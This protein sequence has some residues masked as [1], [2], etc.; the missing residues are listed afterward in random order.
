MDKKKENQTDFSGFVKHFYNSLDRKD[1]KTYADW[2][3]F[4]SKS[5]RAQYNQTK[6]TI[7][8]ALNGNRYNSALEIGPGDGIW[9][10]L[11]LNFCSKIDAIDL[12]E[13]MLRMAKERLNSKPVNLMK[14]DFL[15][16]HFK[17]N[18][19][20]IYSVRCIEYIEDKE[21]LIRKCKSL[22]K[23]KGHLLFVTKNPN[24]FV[25]KKQDKTLHSKQISIIKLKKLLENQGFKVKLVLPA[26]F[27]KGFHFPGFRQFS[28]LLHKNILNKKSGYNF[29]VKH[30]SESFLIFA[31][32]ENYKN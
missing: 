5:S 32:N 23:N 16:T 26:V 3:W 30:F 20:L 8:R 22:L 10:Q 12:S 14:G 15:K 27:G 9:T 18:Y 25:L 7:L 11:L 24:F 28:N 1:C 13:E 4:K 21:L 29:F 2:K 17:G 6:N 19:D 31:E